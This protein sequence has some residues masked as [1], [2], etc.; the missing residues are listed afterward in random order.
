MEQLHKY[1]LSMIK[2]N[3]QLVFFF[4][5]VATIYASTN[6]RDFLLCYCWRENAKQNISVFLSR[7]ISFYTQ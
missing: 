2:H 4:Y 5:T 3:L 6:N 7:N 1:A